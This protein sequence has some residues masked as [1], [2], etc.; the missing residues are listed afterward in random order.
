MWYDGRKDGERMNA[1]AKIAER[2]PI[3]AAIVVCIATVRLIVHL[4]VRFG[5]VKPEKENRVFGDVLAFGAIAVIVLLIIADE[6]WI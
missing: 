5:V 4:L 1:W 6:Y 2:E 3:A